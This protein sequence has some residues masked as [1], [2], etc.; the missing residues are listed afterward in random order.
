[1]AERGYPYGSE[2]WPPEEVECPDCRGNGFIESRVPLEEAI[3]EL[4]SKSD[5]QIIS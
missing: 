2:H 4:V 5:N 1:M 3:K